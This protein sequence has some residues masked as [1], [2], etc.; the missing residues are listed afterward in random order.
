MNTKPVL[1]I[2]AAGLGSR[3]GGTKQIAPV[4]EYGHI[5]MDYAIF[6][7]KRAGFETVVCII[8]PGMEPD[9]RE[10]IGNRI[11]KYVDLKLVFQ[12]LDDIPQ[13]FSIPEGRVKPW[14]TSHAVLSARNLVNGPMAVINADDF[15]GASAF[16]SIC[17]FLVDKSDAS[18]HALVGYRLENTLSEHG[19]VARGVCEVS[20][21]K[22]TEIAEHLHIEKCDNGAESIFADGTI[23]LPGDTVVSMNLW[24][25]GVGMMDE[26]EKR[27]IDFLRN[28]VPMNPL[29]AEY[30][31]PRTSNALLQEGI[32]EFSVL[33]TN[34]VWCGVTYAQDM[35]LVQLALKGMRDGGRYPEK[36]WE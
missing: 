18:H 29:G 8:A 26:L 23:F 5:I 16:S 10:V 1:V 6:D 32:A 30:L 20:N 24:G 15:Y 28:D 3:Y 21:G 33:P 35:P 27:F 19:Y 34:E 2:M 7:A 4:D 13:G 12:R 14:G 17:D 11:E 36:L 25:Y 31:L 22:L 9:F